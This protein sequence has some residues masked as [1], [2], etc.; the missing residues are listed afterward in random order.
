LNA[1]FIVMLIQK[2]EGSRKQS[3]YTIKNLIKFE[4]RS[5]KWNLEGNV[6][7]AIQDGHPESEFLE[8]FSIVISGEIDAKELDAFKIWSDNS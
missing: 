4:I 3:L 6:Y 8:R 7:T 1:G 2:N 5:P